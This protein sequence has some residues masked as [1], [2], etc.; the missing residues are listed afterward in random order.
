MKI[1]IVLIICFLIVNC[2]GKDQ[3]FNTFNEILGVEKTS[4]LDRL[5]SSFQEFLE[6]NYP[7]DDLGEKTR[8]FLFEMERLDNTN[9]EFEK[10]KNKDVINL[11]ETSGLRKEMYIYLSEDYKGK[12]DIYDIFN[13]PYDD[14]T[15]V[16]ELGELHLED[17]EE[18]LIPINDSANSRVKTEINIDYTKFNINGDYLYA[19]A[20]AYSQDTFILEYID[21]KLNVGDISHSLVSG[22][23]L[24]NYNNVELELPIVQR[25]I[26][27]EIYY[28]MLSYI[29]ENDR[30]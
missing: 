2:S 15:T 28:P 7:E 30:K 25:L 16:F 13:S 3:R 27:V 19:L 12:Y 29:I 4:A 20:K 24:S 9:W 10:K 18:E 14:D 8:M 17:I 11:I 23:F 5:V 26:A 6:I 22:G 21:M 1:S